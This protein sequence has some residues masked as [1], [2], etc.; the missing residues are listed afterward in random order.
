M[1][2]E[3]VQKSRAHPSA[4]IQIKLESNA[5]KHNSAHR[6]PNAGSTRGDANL[7]GQVV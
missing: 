5:R 4:P 3:C 2:E 6:L 1:L 7:A